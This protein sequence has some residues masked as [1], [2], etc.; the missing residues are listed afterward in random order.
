MR[1]IAAV[2]VGRSDWGIYR[3]VLTEI[4]DDPDLKLRLIVSGAHLTHQSGY[5]VNEITADGFVVDDKVD[6]L[7]SADSPVGIAKSMGVGTLGFADLYQSNPP[8]ILLILG[9]RFE[10]HAA[11]AAAVPFGIPI[12]HIHGG[13]VTH[14]AIDDAFRHAITKYSHLHF[15]S[16]QQH[17]DRI[18]QLGEEPWRVTVSGAPALDNLRAMS[19]LSREQ[20]EER[21]GLDLSEA[22]VLVTFHPVTLQAAETTTQI[23]E[24]V[25]ALSAL[26]GPIIVTRPN[27][28]THHSRIT[29]QLEQCCAQREDVRLV[30]SL[31]TQAYFSL[32]REARM[33]IGNSSSGIIEAASFRLPVVNIGLRQSGRAKSINV[34]DVDC[35]SSAIID[36]AARACSLPFQN[37]LQNL[38]NPYGEGHA[39]AIITERLKSVPLDDRLLLKRF[40]DVTALTSGLGTAVRPM[41]DSRSSVD[42]STLRQ[43]L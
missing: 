27:A 35:V 34:I 19:F 5:T 22:P 26:R 24:V 10:M 43:E 33:M 29:E 38:R 37:S 20:L 40:H 30:S 16:T 15:P 12:A 3:P 31:G 18:L 41:T 21:L 13:E 1:T 14:G 2:S 9:D 11:A 25:A 6:M 17:A 28:D 32:M 36:A 4:R 8:D 7:M 39:A 42:A 23:K